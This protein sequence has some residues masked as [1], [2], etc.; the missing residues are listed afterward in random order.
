MKKF[1]KNNVKT[2][3]LLAVIFVL[4]L[5]SFTFVFA[6]PIDYGIPIEI[7]NGGDDDNVTIE[8]GAG[9]PPYQTTNIKIQNIIE[10]HTSIT[11]L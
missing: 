8:R 10:N 11:T 5:S 6:G 1:F 9:G 7:N 3:T 2:F 4:V